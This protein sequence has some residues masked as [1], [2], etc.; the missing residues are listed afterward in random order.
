MKHSDIRAVTWFINHNLPQTFL[1]LTLVFT[2]RSNS[3]TLPPYCWLALT[4]LLG[5]PSDNSDLDF[6]SC[7]ITMHSHL[8]KNS[9]TYTYT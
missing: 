4:V 5:P 9:Y 8:P 7:F 6:S 1:L 3:Y 2:L